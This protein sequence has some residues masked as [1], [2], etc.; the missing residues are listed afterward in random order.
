[1]EQG[2]LFV[3]PGLF[4]YRRKD[5]ARQPLLRALTPPGASPL[6]SLLDG[7]LG[8]AHDALFLA[9]AL[10]IDIDGVEAS[11]VLC[12]LLRDGL[13]RLAAHHRGYARPA[14]R[15]RVTH[16]EAAAHLASLPDDAYDAITLDPMFEQ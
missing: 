16:A 4:Y 7:T 5:A 14:S 12:E 6:C 9:H 11:P 1:S 2:A 10:D 13:G 3:N 15:I 8:L